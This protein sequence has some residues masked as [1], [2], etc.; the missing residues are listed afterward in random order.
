MGINLSILI[1]LL[2]SVSSLYIELKDAHIAPSI[3]KYPFVLHKQVIVISFAP[4][5]LTIANDGIW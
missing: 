2:T 3:F 1:Q 4:C 5:D